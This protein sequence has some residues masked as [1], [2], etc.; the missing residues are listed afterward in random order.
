M[1]SAVEVLERVGIE[2]CVVVDK[3]LAEDIRE[4][5]LKREASPCTTDAETAVDRWVESCTGV[6]SKS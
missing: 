3:V 4:V 2:E 1:L 6:L 5:R